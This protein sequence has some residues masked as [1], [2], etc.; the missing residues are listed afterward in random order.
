MFKLDLLPE[1]ARKTLVITVSKYAQNGEDARVLSDPELRSLLNDRELRIL[2]EAIRTELLPRIEEV[3]C[4]YQ[5][6]HDPEEDPEWHMKRFTQLLSGIIDEYP[7]SLR[8][9]NIIEKQRML[10][11]EWVDENPPEEDSS[12]SRDIIVDEPNVSYTSSRSIFDDID[13]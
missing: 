13:E 3:R 8:I 9:R 11:Q 12:I 4:L 10:V 7:H 2:R 1:N 5:E 6:E